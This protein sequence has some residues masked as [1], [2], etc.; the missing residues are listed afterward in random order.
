MQIEVIQ[1]LCNQHYSLLGQRPT[2]DSICQLLQSLIPSWIQ[3]DPAL[4]P[5][6]KANDKQLWQEAVRATDYTIEIFGDVLRNEQIRTQE[7]ANLF[8]KLLI[9]VLQQSTKEFYYYL[10]KQ[11]Q[12][13]KK[14]IAEAEGYTIMDD[15]LIAMTF[16][17]LDYVLQYFP[18]I[19]DM[20]DNENALWSKNNITMLRESSGSISE[21]L[22]ANALDKL[23]DKL[24]N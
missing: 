2:Q 16:N 6:L 22:L 7:E 24:N 17:G 1:Q 3:H 20:N 15:G 19:I 23:M 21:I 12:A 10:L 9:K 14:A 4:L 13:T 5:L 8:N 11:T 18:C